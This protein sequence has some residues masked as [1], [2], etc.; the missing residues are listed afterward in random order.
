[1]DN[2][3]QDY[4]F[5]KKDENNSRLPFLVPDVNTSERRFGKIMPLMGSA[6]LIFENGW[7]NEFLSSHIKD[8]IADVL[9]DASS[10][11]VRDP[12]RER[13][14]KLELP[15]VYFHPAIYVDD[16]GGWHEDFWYLGLRGF[17]DCW[18]RT[19]STYDDEVIEVGDQK[20]FSIYTYSLDSEIIKNTPLQARLLFRMGG[21]LDG[22]VTC[23]KSIATIFRGNGRSGAT[24]QAVVEY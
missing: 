18:S 15:N 16:Q 17:F 14:L 22:L 8:D 21:T 2:F 13:L 1:M 24:L 19:E 11:I 5:L 10:C 7:K 6:P 3:D 20:L 4:F 23:H 9:F 12:I